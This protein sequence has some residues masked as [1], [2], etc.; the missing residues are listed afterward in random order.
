MLKSYGSQCGRVVH[1]SS[2]YGQT[3]ADMQKLFKTVIAP[4]EAY[5]LYRGAKWPY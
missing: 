2:G 4:I 3:V 1:I 5:H